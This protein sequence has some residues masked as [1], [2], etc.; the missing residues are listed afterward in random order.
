[1]DKYNLKLDYQFALAQSMTDGM[2]DCRYF[3]WVPDWRE[4]AEEKEYLVI[5]NTGDRI[6]KEFEIVY[7]FKAEYTSKKCCFAISKDGKTG[8]LCSISKTG[9]FFDKGIYR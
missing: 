8:C 2:A 6:N 1:M 9:S 5:L 7:Q 3:L 4:D